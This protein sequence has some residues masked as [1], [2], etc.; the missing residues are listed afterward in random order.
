MAEKTQ[1]CDEALAAFQRIQSVPLT[2][3]E[4]TCFECGWEERDGEV[5]ALEERIRQLE[6]ALE[7]AARPL[8][9]LALALD[10]FGN[11]LEISPFTQY[12]IIGARAAIAAAGKKGI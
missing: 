3:S 2:A 7:I 9:T 6:N 10:K 1:T 8:G 12:E 11:E 5:A 4:R